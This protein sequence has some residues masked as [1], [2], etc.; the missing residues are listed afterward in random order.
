MRSRLTAPWQ[1]DTVPTTTPLPW[2]VG[3][4]ARANR[5]SRASLYSLINRVSTPGTRNLGL[6][7]TAV[8]N[9]PR[10]AAA[11]S[12]TVSSSSQVRTSRV[13]GQM[14]GARQFV[15]QIQLAALM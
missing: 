13:M 7:T 12:F 14:W 15:G 5:R 6:N 9:S 3:R 2:A 4:A 8:A 1:E 11:Y 10:L